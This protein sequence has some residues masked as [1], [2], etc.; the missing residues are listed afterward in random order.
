MVKPN[1][2]I[3]GAA[4]S[5]TTSLFEYLRRH[6]DI[7]M[8][9]GKE[10]SFFGGRDGDESASFEDYCSYF[11][12]ARGEKR[13]G[14]ASSAYLYCA[15][16]AGKIA[17]F[18]GRDIKIIILLR[19]PVMMAY[20][21]WGH[22]VRNMH[23]DLS[24][25]EAL[26]AE[27]GRIQDSAFRL[28]AHCWLYNYAYLDRVRYAAQVERYLS[29]FGRENVAVFIYEQFFANLELSLKQVYRFLGVDEAFELPHYER[30]N[31]AGQV[32]SR[33]LHRL[34]TEPMRVTAPLRRLLPTAL[35]RGL[36]MRLN[37]V[38]TR[39]QP[40]PALEPELRARL[41][42]QLKDDIE[43]LERLLDLPLV[44]IWSV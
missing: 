34:Y 20:S 16:A 9:P 22:N 6:P 40:L 36:M 18:L 17:E 42:A 24:F 32:R 39:A 44:R 15:D 19:N 5:G 27:A 2:L 25:A 12:G 29:T 31:P 26:E 21:L 30:H 33:L 1:F 11:S 3:V 14:E 35:R 28:T 37:K 7:Y 10:L 4:K 13:I 43:N 23:E 8:A 38:N 41:M